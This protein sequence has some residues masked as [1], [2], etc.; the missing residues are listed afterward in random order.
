MT[1]YQF[2]STN[3]QTAHIRREFDELINDLKNAPP[4]DL[5]RTFGFELET[6]SADQIRRDMTSEDRA[7]FNFTN[8]PSVSEEDRQ[9]CECSCSSC[10]YHECNCDN[11]EDQN[12]D[13][14]HGCGNWDCEG[15]APEFTE[16]TPA[17]FQGL[18][19]T[20]PEHLEALKRAN[21]SSADITELCGLHIHVGSGDLTALQ[22]ARVLTAWR[23]TDHILN[24]IAGMERKNNRYCEDHDENE[25]W[26]AR[27]GN[28]SEKYRAVNTAHHF[29]RLPGGYLHDPAGRPP[30]LEFRRHE[31]TNSVARIRAW[32]WLMIQ[33]VEFAKSDRPVYWLSKAQTLGELLKVIR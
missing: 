5:P 11:C 2:T 25:E 10:N 19:N 22:V 13:P 8:D 1:D 30:T 27:R 9:Q 4:E 16:I 28:G 17:G 12:D 6:P 21:V 24:P 31:G 32:G 7:L 29:S 18:S 3:E 23:M 14:G 33:L 26:H 20:H 15:N